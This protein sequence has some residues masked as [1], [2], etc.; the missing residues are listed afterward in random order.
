MPAIDPY[1]FSGIPTYP[2]LNPYMPAPSPTTMVANAAISRAAGD[3]LGY[4]F[5]NAPLSVNPEL[6]GN[7]RPGISRPGWL[8]N[9][10]KC[11]QFVGDV[12]FEAGF[13]VPVNRMGDG[14]VH[15]R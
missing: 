7:T 8:K 15:Y 4:A 13:R 10:N 6:S 3:S 1:V 11:N 5:S 14:S 12:L 9:V 2:A